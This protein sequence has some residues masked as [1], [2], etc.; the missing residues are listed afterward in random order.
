LLFTGSA[1]GVLFATSLFVLTVI[2]TFFWPQI[3]PATIPI[4]GVPGFQHEDYL[5]TIRVCSIL[6]LHLYCYA[7]TAIFLRRTVFR[8][9]PARFTW[10]VLIF[11]LAMGCVLPYMT[12]YF[13]YY[14]DWRY[15]NVYLWLVSNPGVAAFEV[16]SLY[17]GDFDRRVPFLA[18]AG[19]WAVIITLLNIPWLTRQLQLFRAPV[20]Q[21]PQAEA[22]PILE[23]ATLEGIPG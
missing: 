20:R 4:S 19:I 2:I 18:F 13:L 5:A 10:V 1:G 3:M 23:P 6:F 16:S 21:E 22:A 7:L 12:S 14:R 17:W 15:D 8:S 11:V 9:V